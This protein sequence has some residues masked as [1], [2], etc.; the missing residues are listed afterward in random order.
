[1]GRS[2]ALVTA[3]LVA[4]AVSA[5]PEVANPGLLGTL[6]R[7]EVALLEQ[8]G[9]IGHTTD[10]DRLHDIYLDAAADRL[11][12]LVTTDPF[13][14]TF[15]V[16]YDH[17]LRVAELDRFAP[18]LRRMLR[19]LLDEQERM[20][21]E[22]RNPR[23]VAAL[24]DNVAFLS[25]PLSYLDP[26]STVPTGVASKVAAE[27]ALIEAHAGLAPSAVMGYVE[28]FSQYRPRG[29]YTRNEEFE[30]YF[31]AMV[32]LGRMTFRFDPPQDRK[33]GQHLTRMALLLAQA[34]NT[35]AA[36]D[37]TALGLWQ[38][39]YRPTAWLVGEAED[40]L[41]AD[42]HAV[43]LRLLGDDEP[44]KWLSHSAGIKAFVAAAESLPRPPILSGLLADDQPA[45][46]TFGMRLMGQRYIPDSEILQRLV[47]PEVG[48]RDDPRVLPMAL[49]V[50]A[51]LGSDRARRHLVELYEQDRYA[52]YLERLD[53][54]RAEFASLTPED[55]NRNAY[56]GWL[57]VL[58]LNL[59]PVG[60]PRH[61]S[62]AARFTRS[63]AYADKT[64]VTTGGSWAELRHDTVLYA[65]QS[66]TAAG[67]APPDEEPEYVA[68]V[69][70]KPAV[71]GRLAGLAAELR[72]R[73]ADAGL[74]RDELDRRLARFGETCTRLAAIAQSETDGRCMD[75]E[76]ARF[77]S[78]LG[79]LLEGLATFE[80]VDPE[81]VDPS[82]RFTSEE[83]EGI[84]LVTDVHTD[85]NTGLVLHEAV[86]SPVRLYAIVPFAG[87]D[88]LA[89]GAGFSCY[90]FTRPLAER[91]TDA[92]WQ[93][94]D[95]KPGLPRWTR[96]FIT[97]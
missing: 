15:H 9:L 46:S 96:S 52:G 23:V 61:D 90:E 27:R 80:N 28:D 59:E 37:T 87:R 84:A 51:A 88:W 31:K 97:R 89:V 75:S 7:T 83:D 73:L 29:H 86:G 55:W 94:L 66:Y 62:L 13:L 76:D 10:L 63:E 22:T 1:M 3:C 74:A 77:C 4:T 21:A 34:L 50:M 33:L 19:M 81:A 47:Y 40:P 42:Y 44:L 69:V 16:L 53:S 17:S 14:H 12:V 48:T 35:A 72:R 93:E 64:L 6:G 24:T 39:V 54:L 45:S 58:K 5:M 56:L 78:G 38:R 95:P 30:G 36:G 43:F 79:G 67:A 70:P 49:D 92:E 60:L 71:F 32:Y 68:Y 91:M 18:D 11:P 25:V 65:K 8:Q 2:A 82:D 41:P 85:V 57:H 26:D 20:L